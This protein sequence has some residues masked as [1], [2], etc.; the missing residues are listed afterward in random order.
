MA[1]RL[2]HLLYKAFT[3]CRSAY[4]PGT[5]DRLRSG[6]DTLAW[7]PF[8]MASHMSALSYR[9]FNTGIE[10]TRFTSR[11]MSLMP[12]LYRCGMALL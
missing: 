2:F 1:L 5:P 7:L 3:L 12:A 10:Y 6:Q 9:G 4:T 8:A 11:S